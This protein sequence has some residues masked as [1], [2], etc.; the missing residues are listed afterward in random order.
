M[1]VARAF[2]Q[3]R[4]VTSSRRA[5]GAMLAGCRC[6]RQLSLG[7]NC[8]LGISTFSLVTLSTSP[9]SLHFLPHHH[10]APDK[11]HITGLSSLLLL[12]AGAVQATSWSFDAGSVSVTS[13][14][15]GEAPKER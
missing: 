3:M 5:A 14:K 12:A 10:P 7:N 15:G 2:P 13:K 11:M 6:F 8:P 4:H 1:I 9:I